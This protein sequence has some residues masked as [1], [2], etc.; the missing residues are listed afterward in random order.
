M[1]STHHIVSAS[2]PRSVVPTPT[3]FALSPLRKSALGTSPC[4]HAIPPLASPT[5]P[6]QPMFR[7][8][9]LPPCSVALTRAA[10]R[11]IE[12]GWRCRDACPSHLECLQRSHA[13]FS[14]TVGWSRA[15]TSA[16]AAE[17]LS[18]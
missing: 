16:W 5:L 7:V 8:A 1:P 14:L 18:V 12:S 17:A 10:A 13:I 11:T 6:T 9:P 3:V 2:S 15:P 4:L